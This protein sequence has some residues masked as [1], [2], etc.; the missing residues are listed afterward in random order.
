MER[1]RD[2]TRG[3]LPISNW[4]PTGLTFAQCLTSPLVWLFSSS[5]FWK[6]ILGGS[7]IL[8]KSND[9]RE[10][11]LPKPDTSEPRGPGWSHKE[12]SSRRKRS[13]LHLAAAPLKV[14]SKEAEM[15]LVC[16]KP[17]NSWSGYQSFQTEYPKWWLTPQ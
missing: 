3:S 1:L 2:I 11:K 14:R 10:R 17:K 8:G 15:P 16:L 9:L 6:T 13:V 4:T 7:G 12:D 5:N